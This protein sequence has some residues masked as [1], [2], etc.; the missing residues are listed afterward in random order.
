MSAVSNQSAWTVADAEQLYRLQAWGK[1]YFAIN[2]HGCVVVRPEQDAAHEI[3][4]LEVMQNLQARDLHAPVVVRFS[5]ILKHRL[6]QLHDAFAEAI[7]D[8]QYQNQYC[9]VF[10][11]K[12]N[13]QR[14]VVEEVYR[15]GAPY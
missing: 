4:L 9:A 13:Q 12:V 11:I 2:Q 10:P 14:L 8:N 6:S 3:D 5:N 1:G 15:Y 7:R